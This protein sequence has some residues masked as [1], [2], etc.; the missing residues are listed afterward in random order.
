MGP[1]AQIDERYIESKSIQR[2]GKLIMRRRASI[3]L[4]ETDLT[5]LADYAAYQIG[6]RGIGGNQQSV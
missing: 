5:R 4:I 6:R 1:V 3:D 2:P